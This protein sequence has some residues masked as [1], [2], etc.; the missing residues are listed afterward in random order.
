MNKYFFLLLFYSCL[1]VSGVWALSPPAD[2]TSG[3]SNT[4]LNGLSSYADSVSRIPA[5]EMYCQWDTTVIHPYHFETSVFRDTVNLI[6]T[7]PFS[8]AF[9]MPR[10]GKT[11]SGFGARHRQ[12]HFGVD[13][14]LVTGDSVLSAFDGLVRIAR[15][16]SSYGN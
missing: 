10:I 7:G 3:N 9:A 11:N 14:H 13:I 5:Y 6:L 15:P 8:S 12:P 1:R 4:L 16:N 2:T